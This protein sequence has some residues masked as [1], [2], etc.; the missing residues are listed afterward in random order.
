M[1]DIA[2]LGYKVDSSGLLEGTKALDDNAAAA[3]KAGG[4]A[5]R[6]EKD[7]QALSRT[8]ERSSSALGDRL[9]GAL[10]R[11]GT[12]TGTVIAELQTLNR[13]NA[14]M[15]ASLGAL[16]GKLSSTAAQVQAYGAA[17][18][19]AATSAAKTHAP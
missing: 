7:Y 16:D 10:D 14:E 3:D 13:T 6:L 1:A 2:E 18:S 19:A 9:G 5:E 17:G 15:L 4:A 11:I 12:G 8:I